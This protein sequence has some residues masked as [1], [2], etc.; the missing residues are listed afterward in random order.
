LAAHHQ[1]WRQ[2]ELNQREHCE[3][4]GVPLKGV[5]QLAWKFKAEPQGKSSVTGALHRRF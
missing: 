1:A 4:Y 2:G 5:R 3:A